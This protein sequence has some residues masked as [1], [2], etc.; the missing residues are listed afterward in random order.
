MLRGH[1]RVITNEMMV[2]TPSV[3]LML[4]VLLMFFN[5]GAIYRRLYC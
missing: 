1:D 3:L 4:S 2:I 5:D